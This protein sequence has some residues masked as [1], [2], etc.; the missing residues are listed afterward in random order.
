MPGR[1]RK[2]IRDELVRH[3]DCVSSETAELNNAQ[4]RL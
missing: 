1:R 3:S 2:S 4:P